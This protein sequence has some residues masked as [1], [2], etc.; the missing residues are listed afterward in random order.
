MYCEIQIKEYTDNTIY[1]ITLELN[2]ATCIFNNK[3]SDMGGRY[4]FHENI[5]NRIHGGKL[6]QFY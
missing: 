5:L 4:D 2:F 1:R 6:K 3:Y